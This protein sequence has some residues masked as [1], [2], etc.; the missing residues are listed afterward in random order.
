MSAQ[1]QPV[2]IQDVCILVASHRADSQSRRIGDHLKSRFLEGQNNSSW[3]SLLGAVRSPKIDTLPIC[4]I[5]KMQ[6]GCFGTM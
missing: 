1:A 2:H 4:Q 5:G 6:K 3:R